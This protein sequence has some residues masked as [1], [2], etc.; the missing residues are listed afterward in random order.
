LGAIEGYD[1][2]FRISFTNAALP[3]LITNLIASLEF[4]TDYAIF[5]QRVLLTL[6]F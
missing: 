6:T 4:R 3:D 1:Q 5:G 2:Y